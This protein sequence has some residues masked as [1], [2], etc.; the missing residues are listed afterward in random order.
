[1]RATVK[2]A[3]A[4]VGC[5]VYWLAWTGQGNPP[6]KYITFSTRESDAMFANDQATELRQTVYVEIWST[7]DPADVYAAVKAAMKIAGFALID[8]PEFYDN[9]YY[10]ISMTYYFVG[11]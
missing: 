2:T 6:A 1:M 4:S 9:G 5:P 11:T 7:Q 3:L 8:S 10:H